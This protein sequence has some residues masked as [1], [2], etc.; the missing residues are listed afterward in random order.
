MRTYSG[1]K[2]DLNNFSA[3]DVRILD[4][5]RALSYLCRFNGHVNH[6]FSVAEHS[7]IGSRMSPSPRQAMEFLLHDVGEAFIGDIILPVKEL[8]P[9]IGEFENRITAIIIDKLWPYSGLTP[10]G[11]YKKSPYVTQQDGML[12]EWESLYLRP[13]HQFRQHVW[14]TREEWNNELSKLENEMKYTPLE[15]IFIADYLELKDVL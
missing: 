9:E 8:F 12:A 11:E 14:E 15:D 7:I 6:P 4:V 2:V 3:D 13:T 1:L 5:A 10:L